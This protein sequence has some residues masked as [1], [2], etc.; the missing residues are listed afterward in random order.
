MQPLILLIKFFL[1]LRNLNDTYL[2]GIG[3]YLLYCMVLSFLQMHDACC[4]KSSDDVTTLSNMFV[5]FFY[6]WG[7]IR[8]YDQFVTTVRGLGHVYP[9]VLLNS[10]EGGMLSCESP[11]DPSVDI[12]KNSFNM[13]SAR[14]AFQQAFFVL[15]DKEKILD[16]RHPA[17]FKFERG[18]E[19]ILES[20]YDPSHPIFQHRT[21]SR[22][23]QPTR[24]AYSYQKFP[25]FDD[26]LT[27]VCERLR[28][29]VA[30]AEEG[31]VFNA[32]KRLMGSLSHK[33]GESAEANV[34]ESAPFYVIS[35]AITRDIAL[36]E[37]FLCD[38]VH[39]RPE[40]PRHDHAVRRVERV[41]QVLAV[42]L[43][44]VLEEEAD[45]LARGRGR[46][47]R[48]GGV[49]RLGRRPVGGA[50][51]QQ[52]ARVA[53]AHEGPD[54]EAVEDVHL[55][56]VHGGVGPDQVVDDVQ[57]LVSDEG[58]EV[59][60]VG[61]PAGRGEVLDH[62]RPVVAADDDEDQDLGLRPRRRSILHRH[63]I[64]VD[65]LARGANI[66]H[67]GAGVCGSRPCGARHHAFL[68][69][70]GFFSSTLGVITIGTS[71][72]LASAPP[73]ASPEGAV[74][75]AVV[76]GAAGTASPTLGGTT[77]GAIPDTVTFGAI[78][79]A[80]PLGTIRGVFG[81]ISAASPATAV[82]GALGATLGAIAGAFPSGATIGAT[83]GGNIEATLGATIGATF[84]DTFGAI[85]GASLGVIAGT[86]LGAITG[87]PL[88][89]IFGATAGTPL[90]ATAGATFEVTVGAGVS[91]GSEE[92]GGVGGATLVRALGI[93]LGTA[94]G[95]DGAS[96]TGAAVAGGAGAFRGTFIMGTLAGIAFVRG[97]LAVAAAGCSSAGGAVALGCA[98]AGDLLVAGVGA[99]AAVF[100]V[101]GVAAVVSGVVAG[102]LANEAPVSPPSGRLAYQGLVLGLERLVR[103]RLR[104]GG[105]AH[106]G[107]DLGSRG[108]GHTGR[109]LGGDLDGGLGNL[110]RDSLHKLRWKLGIRGSGA[111]QLQLVVAAREADGGKLG[112]VGDGADAHNGVTAVVAAR[113]G[114]G[115]RLVRVQRLAV[116]DGHAGAADAPL[117][118][119]DVQHELGQHV[120]D[121]GRQLV[122]VDAGVELDDARGAVERLRVYGSRRLVVVAERARVPPGVRRAD[123][124]LDHDLVDD[125]GE[126]AQ[127]RSGTSCFDR[128]GVRRRGRSRRSSRTRW[129]RRRA[130]VGQRCVYGRVE[131][132]EPDVEVA[133]GVEVL[134]EQ[135]QECRLA[136]ALQGRAA[137]DAHEGLDQRVHLVVQHLDLVD[138]LA[139]LQRLAH[140]SADLGVEVL[141]LGVRLRQP[142]ALRRQLLLQAVGGGLALL[143]QVALAVVEHEVV[144]HP[145]LQV[146]QHVLDDLRGG[147][148]AAEGTVSRERRSVRHP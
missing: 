90:G 95:A 125:D 128:R 89:A 23:M 75:D 18:G 147:P 33:D 20:I 28:Q 86:P 6:Y 85:A 30:S 92:V 81:T 42:Q 83:L 94:F 13:A 103:I 122:D 141:D 34:T 140:Q 50:R 117:G 45:G 66:K 19:C 127:R 72:F 82:A 116:H 56:E 136:L 91:A 52:E 107:D 5:D 31:S 51:D 26:S 115:P 68:G 54:G 129:T 65:H 99:G 80:L 55:S 126:P 133:A 144:A 123:A 87:A 29:V 62:Q 60:R 11:L 93:I 37:V 146:V 2:G 88:G 119:A 79:R 114:D 61:P 22:I 137:A 124:A 24:L 25:N 76:V 74:S 27:K 139:D 102:A 78:P 7:F 57:R 47:R 67:G 46:H 101:T 9:R 109:V 41:V 131:R 132:V 97:A 35:E 135:A 12:G 71:G 48:R 53:G 121:P 39:A 134:E 10:R 70:S 84:G 1:Q 111:A 69:A 4:R 100:G 16:T 105:S 21:Q 108:L 49:L 59:R 106:L 77:F 138:G 43:V 44:H 63:G 130:G 17:D 32:Q 145:V 15:R 120:G 118:T 3:S 40:V 113:V 14:V 64:Q 58:G 73:D 38:A 142:G 96:A 8:D 148:V 110:V 112:A 98:I 104:G 36:I 143:A